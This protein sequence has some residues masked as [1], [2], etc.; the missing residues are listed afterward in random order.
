M[1]TLMLLQVGPHTRTLQGRDLQ[2]LL[3]CKARL[4]QLQDLELTIGEK[5]GT[6][7]RWACQWWA[8]LCGA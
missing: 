4:P 5:Y 1:S 8:L 6:C 2:E 3:A 7:T